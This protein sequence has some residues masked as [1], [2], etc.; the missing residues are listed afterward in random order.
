MLKEKKKNH[1]TN[2][3]SSHTVNM[4]SG[5]SQCTRIFRRTREGDLFINGNIHIMREEQAQPGPTK[6]SAR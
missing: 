6:T 1:S 5:D 3:V 4:I 2:W